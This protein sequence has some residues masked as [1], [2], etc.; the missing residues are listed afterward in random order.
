MDAW[1]LQT[2]QRSYQ[3]TPKRSKEL[4]GQEA[5]HHAKGKDGWHTNSPTTVGR[6]VRDIIESAVKQA[7][8]Q[9]DLIELLREHCDCELTEQI[10]LVSSRHGT[11]VVQVATAEPAVLYHLRL[12]WEEPV[13]EVMRRHLPAAGIHTVRFTGVR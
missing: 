3:R 5:V 13:V 12:R 11:L 6:V 10:M 9:Q 1:Y 4:S 7:T 2:R 8:Q